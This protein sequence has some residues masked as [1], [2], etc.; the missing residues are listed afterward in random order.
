MVPEKKRESIIDFSAEQEYSYSL[1]FI[2]ESLSCKYRIELK[3]AEIEKASEVAWKD[4][5]GI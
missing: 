3:H 4:L 5:N 2:K 1:T